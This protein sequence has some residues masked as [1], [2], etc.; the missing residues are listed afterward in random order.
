MYNRLKFLNVSCDEFPTC[1][2]LVD[3]EDRVLGHCKISLIPRLR[4]SCFIQSGKYNY[5]KKM[6][7]VCIFSKQNLISYFIY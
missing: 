2:I 5:K 4:H 1:L 7:Y 3:K 6:E